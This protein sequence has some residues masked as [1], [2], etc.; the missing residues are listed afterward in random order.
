MDLPNRLR[1]VRRT[2]D[3][4]GPMVIVDAT[5]KMSRIYR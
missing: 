2:D 1:T 5:V 3:A 4:D